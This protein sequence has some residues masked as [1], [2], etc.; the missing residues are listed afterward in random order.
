MYT[1]SCLLLPQRLALPS[2]ITD[3]ARSARC[4]APPARRRA[5][6]RLVD[7][8]RSSGPEAPAAD[9]A[10]TS[11]AGARGTYRIFRA[12]PR[13]AGSRPRLSLTSGG[14][15]HSSYCAESCCCPRPHPSSL[16]QRRGA[17]VP[18]P[19]GA[20]NPRRSTTA[21]ARQSRLDIAKSL[22]FTL[23]DNIGT[24]LHLAHG[25][26]PPPVTLLIQYRPSH[27][28]PPMPE[29]SLPHLFSLTNVHQNLLSRGLA[30]TSCQH[31]PPQQDHHQERISPSRRQWLV[32][33]PHQGRW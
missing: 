26:D 24:S 21:R 12:R 22:L 10:L 3:A 2:V 18:S 6:A 32:R 4:R 8:H 20:A 5:S 19:Q 27:L 23:A 15:Q 7:S 13:T 11:S 28:L 25:D 30:C 17:S 16:A 29:H 9:G 31:G 33:Q 14:E 1:K